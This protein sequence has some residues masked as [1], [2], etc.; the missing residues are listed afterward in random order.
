MAKINLGAIGLCCVWRLFLKLCKNFLNLTI[1]LFVF[2]LRQIFGRQLTLNRS[3]ELSGTSL[4][5]AIL[6]KV[7]YVCQER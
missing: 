2:P 4:W 1:D 3:S 5:F 7:L 6:N